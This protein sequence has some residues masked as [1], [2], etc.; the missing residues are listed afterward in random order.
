MTWRQ[1]KSLY[2]SLYLLTGILSILSNTRAFGQSTSVTYYTSD[3]YGI[4]ESDRENA[5]FFMPVPSAADAKVSGKVDALNFDGT[6]YGYFTFR[7]GKLNGAFEV[8]YKEGTKWFKGQML[9]NRV[10]G[11]EVEWY[12][13]GQVKT[14]RQFI[15]AKEDQDQNDI[16]VISHWD[17]LGNQTIQGGNGAY[18]EYHPNQTIFLRG[19]YQEG[20]KS[21]LWESFSEEGTLLYK[22]TYD[23]GEFE[24]GTSFNAKGD[25][26]DYKEIRVFGEYPGGVE[27]WTSYL[28]KNLKYPRPAT[29]K[30]IQGN[31]YLSFII[32]EDGNISGV[33]VTRGIGGGCDEEAKRVLSNSP[34]W[35]PMLMRGQKAKSRVHIQINFR[36]R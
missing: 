28:S 3:Q 4:R 11:K 25:S 32:D 19:S 17:S 29:R 18:T 9:N 8:L 21:G 2:L 26:F 7:E 24:G 36:L 20:K 6:P 13:N 15:T 23:K 30:G 34:K 35:T 5:A 31:V 27:A 22:E 1:R 12:R 14:Q 33:G 10:T 16:L